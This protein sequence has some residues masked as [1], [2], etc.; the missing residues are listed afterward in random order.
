M[1]GGPSVR[2]RSPAHPVAREVRAV[3]CH[4]SG[5]GPRP[6]RAVHPGPRSRSLQPPSLRSPAPPSLIF[7]HGE[8]WVGGSFEPPAVNQ[9]HLNVLQS[10]VFLVP[11]HKNGATLTSSLPLRS[12]SAGSSPELPPGRQ[13]PSG[14]LAALCPEPFTADAPDPVGQIGG[15]RPSLQAF[16]ARRP[17]HTRR[18]QTPP[19]RPASEAGSLPQVSSSARPWAEV[20]TKAQA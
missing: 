1:P 15:A 19:G 8:G 4:C 20:S 10:L 16:Q 7:V 17:A 18:D 12:L 6:L 9:T 2:R 13:E 3:L 5:A 14:L 11:G